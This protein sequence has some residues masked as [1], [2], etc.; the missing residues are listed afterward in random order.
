MGW[1]NRLFAQ[2]DL[3]DPKI[4]VRPVEGQI[5]DLLAEIKAR[6]AKNERA[7]VTTLTKKMAEDLDRLSA[8]TRHQS[9]IPA[10]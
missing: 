7:L 10:F 9:R 3:L 5:D 1:S 8:G 6:V 2:Q 4:D